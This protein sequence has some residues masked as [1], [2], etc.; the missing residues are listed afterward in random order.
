MKRIAALFFLL[1][2]TAT[3]AQ[4]GKEAWHWRFGSRCGLDF[5]TGVPLPETG[6]GA[7]YQTSWATT[8]ISDAN[9]G[10]YLFSTNGIKIFNKNNAVMYNG[11]NIAG[12]IEVSQQL[13]IPKPDS[14]GIYYVFTPDWA[15]LTNIGIH[16]CEVDMS[17]QGGLGAVT[18]K[19][20]VLTPGPTTDKITAV[21]HCNGK[22]YWV[23]THPANSNAFNA[24]LVTKN[25]ISP[26]VISNVGTAH[27]YQV[28]YNNPLY[29][30][31]FGQLKASPNGKKIALG[32]ESYA[33]PIMELFDF[34]NSTGIVSN[35]ITVNYPGLKGP[36]ALTF[37]PDNSKLY[38]VPHSI[39][40]DTTYIYQYDLSSGIAAVI[41]ASQT[42]VTQGIHSQNGYMNYQSVPQIGPDGKIYISRHLTDT[43]AVIN[44]PNNAGLACNYQYAGPKMPAPMKC[45]LG[46]P[47]FVDANY[48]GIQVNV[49]DILQCN[50][51]TV[52]TGDAGPGFSSYQWSTGATTQ[53]IN[54]TAPGNY[55]VTVTNDQGCQRTDSI[56]AFVLIGNKTTVL[57]CDS[58]R[59]NVV[60]GGVL[61]YNW[62]DGLQN[63]IRDFT[64]S[65]QYWV[66]INYVSGCGIRDSINLTV[67]PSPQIDIGP[68]STFCKGSLVMNASCGTC[69]YQWSTGATTPSIVATTAGVYSVKVTDINGC[70]DADTLVVNPDQIAFNFK[71]PNI[72]TPNDDK[73]N[74]EIDFGTLQLSQ[75]QIEIFN[76]W[77]QKV[78]SSDSVDAVWKPTVDDGTYFYTAQYK[79]DCGADTKTKEIQGF[80]TVVK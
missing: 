26:P 55:W 72:V 35:P 61:Q 44:N 73:I 22:D 80:I 71:M 32:I 65:G 66:D 21:R 46:L 31:G 63:P 39:H 60:Q 68:D 74:D 4:P 7:Q 30:E 53:T 5:S 52:T 1:S 13:I 17:K 56:G 40:D 77:G 49:P 75:L 37:S 14:A 67:V 70:T 54:I 38:T 34:N 8:S 25:G 33:I 19:N 28:M 69:N 64:Q 51:F 43:L 16:Y 6:L 10:Q 41:I 3:I 45:F 23:L 42:Q 36:W 20:Q 48:A 62:Y 9:T 57:A 59:A 76:R 11:F 58:F 24:Y 78:F 27:L 79:I 47:G 50:S 29:Y 15:S 12:N 2:F 18:V